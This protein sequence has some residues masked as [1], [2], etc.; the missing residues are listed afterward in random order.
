MIGQQRP[1]R[2]RRVLM[3]VDAVGG[4]WRYAMDLAAALKPKN[5]EVVFAGLGPSPTEEK[6]A[7]ANR[8]GKLVWLDAPLDWMVQ[9]QKAVA[10]VPRL[11]VDLAHREQADLLHLNLPSQAANMKTEL[12]VIVVCHSC[13][14]TW[15]AAVRSSEVL[16]NW[17][18]QHRLNLAGFARANAVIAPSRSHAV[19]MD[20]AYGRIPNL[21]V[22][23]N[24]SALDTSDEPKQNFILAAGRWWDDGKN[25]AVLDAAAALARWPVIA[26]G[27]SNGPNGQCL[28]FRN[29]DHRGELAHGRLIAL[30][31]QAGVVASPSVYEPFGLAALEAARGGAALVLSDIP[32]YREI[33]NDAAL[34]A[35]PYRPHSFADAFNCLADDPQLRAALALKARARSIQFGPQAQ[36][37][38]MLGIYSGMFDRAFS[39]AAE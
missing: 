34:F 4:V 11:V 18:W 38:A 26:V 24:S 12:P 23:H 5:I 19:A 33:W 27:E 14:V 20:A 39:T 31:R 15:F 29:A 32:T 28:Q 8:N 13:V 2:H 21:K 35:D 10:K 30:M 17:Q 37:Q 16:P 22:V 6:I 3:T 25:G 9:D 7:E 1:N 36:A